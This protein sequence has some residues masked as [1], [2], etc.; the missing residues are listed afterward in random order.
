MKG[1]GIMAYKKRQDKKRKTLQKGEYI[2][3]SDGRYCFKYKNPISGKFE[4]LYADTL[5]ELREKE[6]AILDVI[7]KGI[8]IVKAREMTVNDLFKIGMEL[9]EK[10]GTIRASTRA[11]YERMW[12]YN[13]R[14][15]FGERKVAEVTVLH[16]RR[17]IADFVAGGLSRSTIKLLH[18]LLA[19][20]FDDAVSQKIRLDNPCRDKTVMKAKANGT[21]DRPR[22]ALTPDEQN[23]LLEFVQNSTIYNIHYDFLIV[24]LYTGLRVGEMMALTWDDIDL[25]EGKIRV[26]KQLRYCKTSS[27]GDTHFFIQ[28]PKTQAGIR[29]VNFGDEV[30][31]ALIQL[32][33]LNFALGKTQKCAEVDGVSGFIF[34]S[35]NG[36]PYAPNAVNFF[37]RNIV[38]AYNKEH[39]DKPL[40]VISAHILRHT[41]ATRAVEN[42]MDYKALQK[43]MGH[44]KISVTMDVY[45]K[46]NDEE[47]EREEQLK[48][49]ISR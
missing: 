24:A 48:I 10:E 18:G 32:K 39:P 11:N 35:K 23:R 22:E 13:I 38:K 40:P 34:L 17:L 46:P 26:N 6:K 41:Y 19:V 29:T 14:D 25:K 36:N 5:D 2:R 43:A 28:E 1:N 9:K 15:D 37:L 27:D 20:V 30:R 3:S 45:A 7:G 8:D 33:R 21:P 49:S 31:N 47:W 16:A 12:D 42:N 44:S 4:V